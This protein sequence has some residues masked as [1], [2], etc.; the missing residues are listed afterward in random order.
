MSVRFLRTQQRAESQ[1]HFLLGAGACVMA[2]SGCGGVLVSGGLATLDNLFL[3]LVDFCCRA[4][5]LSFSGR[6]R[7]F[8]DRPAFG[9]VVI[10]HQR[11]V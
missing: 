7:L 2:F 5:Q 10:V 3:L 9:L 4:Q 8:V 11:R 1:C 6:Q